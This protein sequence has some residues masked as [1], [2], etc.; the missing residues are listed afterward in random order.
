MNINTLYK[1]RNDAEIRIIW[2][3]AFDEKTDCFNPIYTHKTNPE[4]DL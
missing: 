2:F 4:N 1:I 3:Q